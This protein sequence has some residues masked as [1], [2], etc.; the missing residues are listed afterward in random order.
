[1]GA[2]VQMINCHV[3]MGNVDE[4]RKTLQRASWALG[5]IPDER[6]AMLPPTQR[7]PFWEE[8]LA[9]LYKTP[10]FEPTEPDEPAETIEMVDKGQ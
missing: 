6:F 9:W 2:Y 10:L 5:G 7:R 3:R 8:Y 4:A 1:M